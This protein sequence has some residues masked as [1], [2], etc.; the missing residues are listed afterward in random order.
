[1]KHAPLLERRTLTLLVAVVGASAFAA[2]G[3]DDAR[4]LAIAPLDG[5][6][7]EAPPDSAPPAV[8]DG[9]G[10]DA[11][12]DSGLAVLE[13]GELLPGG[14]TTT[15]NVG[16]GAFTAQAK[17]LALARR[18]EFEA[19]LQFFQLP[20]VVAPGRPE[21]DGLGP[22]FHA[23]SCL[24]CHVRNGRGSLATV[25]LRIGLGPNNGP[26][27]NYG[28]QLQ[29]FG[30]GPV[31]GEGKP[32]RA[33][34]PVTHTKADGTTIDLVAPSY[35]ITNLGFGPFGADLR[36]SPRIA[37]QIVGQGLL[38]AISDADIAAFED[39]NDQ[40]GDGISG[41]VH[42]V[43]ARA[44]R[45]GWKAMHASVEAQTAAAF[46][47]DLGITSSRFPRPNCPSAQTGC[48]AAPSGGSPELDASRLTVTVAYIRL[49][50]VPTRRGG[51][52]P[53]VLRGKALFTSLGCASCH[54]PSF[55]TRA[56]AAEPELA[57]QHIWP[58]SDL[59]LHD[60]GER[61]ADHRR[62]GDAGERE[63]R[64]PPLWSLGLVP[65]VNGTR[66]LLHDGRARSIDEAIAWHD[67]EAAA[68][69]LAWEKLSSVDQ[70]LLRAFVE[71][72]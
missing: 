66:H 28:S 14:A 52:T 39:P 54:R 70:A 42:W 8:V 27:P 18:G 50:G 35:E 36:V 26:D 57:T 60:L 47:E 41:R 68:A 46:S 17:N 58:Y 62:E 7:V 53:D 51:E 45:F 12:V 22:T 29:P 10:A 15:D 69:R 61:L 40:D 34:V 56:D 33:D 44:G 20:W 72:L 9:G 19:G 32:V 1:V 55:V 24:G 5:G 38:E 13:D 43:D 4:P 63:W 6:V 31:P 67:G 30:I 49:L 2:C 65:V 48:L 16:I 21:A 3:E 25:L 37:P 64:T 71:S 59:L 23:D 11:T